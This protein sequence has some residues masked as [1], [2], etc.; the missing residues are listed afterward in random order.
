[1]KIFHEASLLLRKPFPEIENDWDYLKILLMF[2]LFV[3]FFLYIFQPFGIDTLE[4]HKFFICLGFGAMTFLG[5]AVY[6]IFL[7]RVLKIRKRQQPWTF[8][9]W[10]LDSLGIM[11][12]I[13][14]AN[15]L[16]ARLLLFGYI[17]WDLFPP[18]L[19][20]TFMIGIIPVVTL[21]AFALLKTE[22]KYQEIA[23]EI[24]QSK[25]SLDAEKQLNKHL[26]FGIPIHQIR[27]IEA[28]QN[29]AKIGFL[30][31]SGD[32]KVKIERT[33]LKR[34][35]E[36]TKDTS[37]IKSHRSFLVNKNTILNSTGNAQGLLLILAD[38]DKVIPVSRTRVK[39]FR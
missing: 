28:L 11:L 39:F 37:I 38:C 2:S 24:N 17:Q 18:M 34:I 9:K 30:N 7:H 5:A 10:I 25:P 32:F 21:G 20:S 1:M 23:Q 3:T 33:T 14:L 29:Y 16:F 13:S 15:F 12:F 27:Y 4:S 6:E 35:L 31:K 19:Y 22:K 26:I 36:E 8:G